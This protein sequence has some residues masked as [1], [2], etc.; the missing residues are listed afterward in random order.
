MILCHEQPH[1]LRLN[2]TRYAYT[3]IQFIF[4]SFSSCTAVIAS[5]CSL[6]NAP[7]VAPR[8]GLDSRP[9]IGEQF[10]SH[11]NTL[12]QSQPQRSNI[13]THIK[14]RC[15]PLAQAHARAPA[16]PRAPQE[17]FGLSTAQCLSLLVSTERRSPAVASLRLLLSSHARRQLMD[18]L[19]ARRRHRWRM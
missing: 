9:S 19:F 4:N 18:A 5:A 3:S 1:T 16:R 7:T 10:Q 15:L 8:A 13:N 2:K 11:I 12:Q 6:Y 14:T 17:E